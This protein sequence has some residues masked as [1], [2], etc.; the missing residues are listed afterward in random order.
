MR[1][2]TNESKKNTRS[3]AINKISN[4]NSTWN[5]SKLSKRDSSNERLNTFESNASNSGVK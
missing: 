3:F 4:L 2:R 1:Y 5:I